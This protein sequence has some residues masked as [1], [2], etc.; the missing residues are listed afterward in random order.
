MIHSKK[1]S[2][3]TITDF[4]P[5]VGNFTPCAGKLKN[6]LTQL[7]VL[8]D[9]KPVGLRFNITKNASFS[10]P[11]TPPHEKIKNRAAHIG[12]SAVL[13]QTACHKVA[14]DNTLTLYPTTND[15]LTGLKTLY[16]Q[17]VY[18]THLRMGEHIFGEIHEANVASPIHDATTRDYLNTSATNLIYA[19]H[20]WNMSGRA[21]H[22]HLENAELH[23]VILREYCAQ[24]QTEL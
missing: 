22:T 2:T 4:R 12:Y 9:K 3:E 14:Y 13:I 10:A 6:A 16:D 5:D 8:S 1:F 23:A 15:A 20:Y 17:V 21:N 11:G 7:A 18:D 19:I 24:L